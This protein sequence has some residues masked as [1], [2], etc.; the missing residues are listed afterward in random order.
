MRQALKTSD[1]LNCNTPL[2]G[3]NYC[4]NCGQKNDARKLSLEHV[5][6]E[7]FSSSFSFDGRLM[8]T[9]SQLIK[10]PG[11]VP[12]LFKKGKRTQFMHPLRLYLLSSFLLFFLLNINVD[13]DHQYINPKINEAKIAADTI[14]PASDTNAISLTKV[15]LARMAQ[16]YRTHKSTLPGEALNTLQIENS[17]TNRFLYRQASKL[18]DFD[19]AAFNKYLYS[20]LYWVFFL[21]VPVLALILKFIYLRHGIFYTEHVFFIFYNQS[22]LFLLL[23]LSTFI[24]LFYIPVNT[25][26]FIISIAVYLIYLLFAIKRYYHQSWKK[27]IFKFMLINIL[28]APAFLGFF[29]LSLMLVFILF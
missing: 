8:H 4:P 29:I 13:P 22:L 20:K 7:F 10:K 26:L 21:F 18:S 16:F 17:F 24:G 27:T 9:L 14:Q 15:D 1:C 6:S 11:L 19:K 23:A 5:I 2:N 3:E 28:T 25:P 12:L